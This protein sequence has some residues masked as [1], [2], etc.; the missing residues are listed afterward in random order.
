MK[1]LILTRYYT[2]DQTFGT[3]FGDQGLQLVTIEQ[4]WC[5]NIPF[6]S[7]VPEGEYTVIRDSRPKHSRT[8][9]LI[10]EDLGITRYPAAGMRDSCL[11]H[12][13]NVVTDIEGCIGPGLQYGYVK[14][15]W[16]VVASV[17]AFRKLDSYIGDDQ[18]FNLL[19]RQYKPA[20]WR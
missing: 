3:L 13:A 20:P 12:V 5:D 8:F 2:L 9:T 1:D 19:I 7:C 17:P 11:F 16:A 6:K 14:N 4:P 10:N 18:E 15:M